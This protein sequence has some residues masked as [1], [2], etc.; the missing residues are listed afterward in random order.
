MAE[1]KPTETE[2]YDKK[3]VMKR[4][5]VALVAGIILG[6][7]IAFAIMATTIKGL[8]NQMESTGSINNQDNIVAMVNV[9]TELS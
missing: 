8:S 9:G 5:G 2:M 6:L 3:A 1:T 7:V 4:E